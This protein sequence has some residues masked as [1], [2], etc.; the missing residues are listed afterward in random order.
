M[1]IREGWHNGFKADKG[2]FLYPSCLNCPRKTCIE[3]DTWSKRQSELRR[4]VKID[5]QLYNHYTIH[6]IPDIFGN[7]Y[8]PRFKHLW[9]L[10]REK[11]AA[12]PPCGRDRRVSEA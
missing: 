7:Q 3:D 4:M 11:E 10:V 5:L 2:C 1:R 9:H 8:H 12:S 6:G